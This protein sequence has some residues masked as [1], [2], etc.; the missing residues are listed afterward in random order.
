MNMKGY[1]NYASTK[2][3][4]KGGRT[5]CALTIAEKDKAMSF[6]SGSAV[7]PSSQ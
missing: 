6:A 1:V 2:K 7:F 4:E 5:T 3:K